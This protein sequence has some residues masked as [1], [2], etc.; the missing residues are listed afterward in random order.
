MTTTDEDA[1]LHEPTTEAFACFRLELHR[2]TLEGDTSTKNAWALLRETSRSLQQSAQRAMR[3]VVVAVGDLRATGKTRFATPT[4][5]ADEK[6]GIPLA[7][8]CYSNDDINSL[9]VSINDA[10]KASGASEYV[11]SSVA[12][13]LLTSELSSA[14]LKDL[15][16][17]DCTYPD[18][19]RIGIMMRSRNWR[20]TTETRVANG[21]TYEDVV[22]EIGALK[23]RTGK[24]RLVCKSL[25]GP[26]LS[27]SRNLLKALE[28]MGL[29]TSSEDGWSKGALTIRPLRRPGQAEK[30]EILLPYSSP[31]VNSAKSPTSIAVHRSV[32]NMLTAVC[33]DGAVHH[34]SGRDVVLLK[35]QMYARRKN[36]QRDISSNPHRGRGAKRH[37]KALRRLAD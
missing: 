12:R 13:K 30:W 3:D 9:G 10:F 1:I 25:H 32:A 2:P 31:R 6:L 21:K 19:S 14:R 5:R 29:A 36:V 8:E 35:H 18:I 27:R 24:V 15:L 26:K 4:E 34:F 17:G 33:S 23:P 28:A 16:R 7:T 37:F 20:L 22:V 11:Y